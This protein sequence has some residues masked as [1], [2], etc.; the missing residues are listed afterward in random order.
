MS[1]LTNDMEV[2]RQQRTQT[3]LVLLDIA[4]EFLASRFEFIALVVVSVVENDLFEIFP[5]SPGNHLL[6]LY[7]GEKYQYDS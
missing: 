2:L 1:M 5:I 4:K 6:R 7:V 3:V